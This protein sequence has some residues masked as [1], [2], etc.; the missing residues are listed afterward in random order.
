MTGPT[1]P[2]ALPKCFGTDYF[3]KWNQTGMTYDS[4]KIDKPDQQQKCCDCQLFER[5]YMVNEIKLARIRR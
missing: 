5:C 1:T 2:T 4:M 3:G